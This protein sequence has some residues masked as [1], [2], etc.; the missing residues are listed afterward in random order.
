MIYFPPA[1][2]AAILSGLSLN[3]QE[4]A[5]ESPESK[6]NTLDCGA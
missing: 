3:A 1:N 6:D 4:D 2:A 5:R